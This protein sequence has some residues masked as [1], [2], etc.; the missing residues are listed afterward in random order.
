VAIKR[1]SQ[2][3][4]TM[5]L[6]SP[7]TCI[8][9][10]EHGV[11]PVIAY[12]DGAVLRVALEEQSVAPSPYPC[13]HARSAVLRRSLRADARPLLPDGQPPG[14]SRSTALPR[15]GSVAWAVAIPKGSRYRV[16]ARSGRPL[17]TR[18]QIENL[19]LDPCRGRLVPRST[20]AQRSGLVISLVIR[21]IRRVPSGPDWIDGPPNVSRADPSGADQIDAEHQA[22]D[23]AVGGSNRSRRATK[24]RSDGRSRSP[25][26]PWGA[27]CMRLASCWRSGTWRSL[28][29]PSHEGSQ[30]PCSWSLRTQARLS[31]PSSRTRRCPTGQASGSTPQ[32]SRRHSTAVGYRYSSRSQASAK[33]FLAP[34]AARILDDKV[35]DVRVREDQMQF[36]IAPQQGQPGEPG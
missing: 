33:V 4:N 8:P 23:L 26:L 2:Q 16:K 35:L 15:A 3:R 12:R 30:N 27:R 18:H 22:T 5:P 24:P 19:V 1:R 7:T 28:G 34:R 20:E 6:R 17:C 36:V 32:T 10:G 25:C 13:C 31:S 14:P 9:P 21:T 11:G 29:V